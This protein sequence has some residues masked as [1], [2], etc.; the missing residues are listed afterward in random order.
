[1]PWQPQGLDRIREW[2]RL[3][4]PYQKPLV[5]IG[6][7][8]VPRAQAVKTTRVGSVAMISAITRAADY[9]QVVKDLLQLWQTDNPLGLN[10]SE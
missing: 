9:Q 4:A 5:A 8:D 2:M 7:I 3:L 10:V 1:M 6:G